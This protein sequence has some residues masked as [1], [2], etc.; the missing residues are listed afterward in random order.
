MIACK[1]P[2]KNKKAIIPNKRK[3]ILVVIDGFGSVLTLTF[4]E[5]ALMLKPLLNNEGDRKPMKPTI[6]IIK[7][8]NKNRQ[9]NIN[10]MFIY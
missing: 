7:G 6:D 9:A 10:A 8:T 4:L 2:K 5:L 3:K 1:T